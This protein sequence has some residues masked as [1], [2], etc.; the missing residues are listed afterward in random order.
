MMIKEAVDN[1]AK[2]YNYSFKIPGFFSYTEFSKPQ[3]KNIDDITRYIINEHVAVIIWS[4]G[5]KTISYRSEEDNFDKE[6]GF[7]FAYLYKRWG[8][9]KAATKRVINSIDYNN[10][11]T[12]LFEFF[13]RDNRDILSY[14]KARKYLNNLKVEEK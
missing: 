10:I 13:A 9:S 8:Q 14:E 5:T 2:Q 1:L 6:L 12:F 3:P 7:L 4:D 11:K